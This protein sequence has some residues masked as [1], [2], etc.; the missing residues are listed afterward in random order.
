MPGI[1]KPQNVLQL[2]GTAKKDP[3]KYKNRGK[4]P[5][6]SLAIGRCPA[7]L[8]SEQRRAWWEIVGND[9]GVLLKSDRVSVELAARLMA[10]IRIDPEPKASK[11]SLLANLLHKLG[12]TPTGRNYVSIP[13]KQESNPFLKFV[14]PRG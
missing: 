12:Q 14:K 3:K 1:R 7:G 6:D 4:P 10:E 5:A 11:Q 2:N 8:T 13:E 9:P